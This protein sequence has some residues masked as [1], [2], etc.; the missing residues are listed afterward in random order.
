MNWDGIGA[1]A[2]V[3]AA[4][5]VIIT[6]LY[7]AIQIREQ[8][9]ESRLSATRELARDWS[10]GLRFISG[11]D[12]NMELYQRAIADYAGL[13]GG[14]RIRAYMMFSSQIRIIE[15]QHFHISSGNLEP[16]LFAGMEYR[17]KQMGELPGI[18]YWWANN[19]EQY[20]SEFV[21]FAEH[22]SGLGS[23]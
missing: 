16:T 11:D 12:S 21:N 2:D 19:K 15:I 20:N 6:L 7:L 9:K 10:E 22:V 3:V 23:E 17:I 5:G 18:R 14:D 13:S 4:F 1:F 8:T